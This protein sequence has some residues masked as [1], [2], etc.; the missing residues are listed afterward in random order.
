MGKQHDPSVDMSRLAWNRSD[1]P[2]W[3]H[4]T[5]RTAAEAITLEEEYLVLVARK[6]SGLYVTDVQPGALEDDE[7]LRA[8]FDG[9]REVER[10]QA[11][12]VLADDSALQLKKVGRNAW[13]HEA[14]K[15]SSVSLEGIAVGFAWQEDSVW[16]Y[17]RSLWD[18]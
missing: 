13:V 15:G 5:T 6:P 9:T 3:F 8:L 10:V 16:H 18:Y 11:A 7:L 17:S 1:A 14:P 4:Y 2:F 12:A